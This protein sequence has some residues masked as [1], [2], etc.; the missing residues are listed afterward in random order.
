MTEHL[1][2]ALTQQARTLGFDCVGVTGPGAIAEAAKH[3]RS[4]LDTGA[5]GDMD[6]LAAR[7]ERR[8]DPRG[9]WPGVRTVI[10][11]GVNYGPDENPLA[12][13]AQRTSGAISVYARGADYHDL[14]KKGVDDGGRWRVG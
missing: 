6:W 11:L 2:D 3:F 4:F 9:L 5:H 7:P 12:I 10:M 8:P 14:I 13:L 1:R